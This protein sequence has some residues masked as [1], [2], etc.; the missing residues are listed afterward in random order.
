M[1]KKEAKAR[2]A[3]YGLA[4][5]EHRVVRVNIDGGQFFKAF[6]TAEAASVALAAYVVQGIPANIVGE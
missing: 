4:L 2:K 3:A 5:S 1:T 6:T